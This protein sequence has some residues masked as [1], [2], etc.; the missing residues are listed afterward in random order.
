MS[1]PYSNNCSMTVKNRDGIMG[2]LSLDITLHQHSVIDTWDVSFRATFDEDE[3]YDDKVQLRGSFKFSVIKEALEHLEDDSIGRR[4]IQFVS[5]AAINYL[6]ATVKVTPE[7]IQKLIDGVTREGGTIVVNVVDDSFESQLAH[8]SQ[9][10]PGIHEE[11][12]QCPLLGVEYHSVAHNGPRVCD[13]KHNFLSSMIIHLND[14]HK[15]SR[16]QI[17]DWV[18]SLPI[19]TSFKD[20]D[21]TAL[22]N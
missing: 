20:E 6:A 15:W 7:Q 9:S 22:G 14:H 5:S 1:D 4:A 2:L 11:I 13:R 18:E 16:E 19:D 10:L 17:A 21:A 8:F 12:D 3:D